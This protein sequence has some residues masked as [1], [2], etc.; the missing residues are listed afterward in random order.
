MCTAHEKKAHTKHA[1]IAYQRSQ[2]EEIDVK[3]GALREGLQRCERALVVHALL[4]LHSASTASQTRP[5]CAMQEYALELQE[6][7]LNGQLGRIAAAL[8][9]L[10][11][12]DVIQRLG[13]LAN[14]EQANAGSASST[15]A[16]QVVG[17]G[18]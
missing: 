11:Q 6:L 2:I 4:Q 8:Q 18:V 9:L 14:S 17:V 1:S 5:A 13:W 16:I 3:V 12:K 7:G 10:R 15:S